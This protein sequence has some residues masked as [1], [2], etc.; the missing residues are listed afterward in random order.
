M[1]RDQTY[2]LQ[3]QDML[4]ASGAQAN[5]I[6]GLN[7]ERS[8]RRH[9]LK[10][11]FLRPVRLAGQDG[12][13][14]R[15]GRGDATVIE[16]SHII[17]VPSDAIPD[18]LA[19]SA[20]QLEQL[21]QHVKAVSFKRLLLASEN[22]I[23]I[24]LSEEPD[25]RDYILVLNAPGFDPVLKF[26][27]FRFRPECDDEFD[28]KPLTFAE[29][30][31]KSG[32]VIDYL[33]RDYQSLR[34]VL[35]DRLS[36]V[37]PDWTDR[38][39]ADPGVALVELLAYVGDYLSYRQD[40]VATEANFAFARQRSSM[41]RH[42]RLLGYSVD[43]GA[44]ARVAIQL[45]VPEDA[46][47]GTI[48]ALS[49]L[50]FLTDAVPTEY[51]NRPPEE[52]GTLLAGSAVQFFEPSD[53]DDKPD[54]QSAPDR[55]TL[56]PQHDQIPLHD[57]GDRQARLERN[58]LSA[59]LQV[60]SAPL[61]LKAGDLV[62]LSPR[63][64]PD[65][66][67]LGAD[68]RHIVRLTHIGDPVVDPVGKQGDSGPQ[69]LK[70]QRIEWCAQDALP[71]AIPIGFS[72]DGEPGGV[73]MGNLIVAD[74]GI[75]VDD[76]ETLPLTPDRRAQD[77]RDKD[78]SLAGN[79]LEDLVRPRRYRPVLKRKNIAI[80]TKPIDL[81]V[82]TPA[83]SIFGP[84]SNTGLPDVH[85]SEHDPDRAEMTVGHWRP[86][87]STIEAASTDQVF[88]AE[89]EAD[90]LT[91]LRFG[92]GRFGRSPAPNR[93]FKA[94]YRIGSGPEGNVGAG[95]IR[96]ILQRAP[97]VAPES[98][99]NPAPATGGRR[100]ESNEEIRIKAPG[101]IYRQR[102]AITADDYAART[103]A[104][105]GVQRV[106][107]KR[108]ETGSGEIIAITVDMIGGGTLSDDDKH[109]LTQWVEPYRMMGHRLLFR[110]PVFVPLD[111]RL[112][113]CPLPDADRDR[114]RQNVERRL[115]AAELS[116]GEFGFFHP[117]RLTFG[118]EI[119][120]SEIVAEAAK[121]PRV[122][123]VKVISLKRQ[124]QSRTEAFTMGRLVFSDREIPILQN[125]RQL[126][127]NGVLR[128]EM[129]GDA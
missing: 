26:L 88:V 117:D 76:G 77:V 98:C 110:S 65:N 85:L 105:E 19:L 25:P 15:E 66:L 114:I 47:N 103:M 52:L 115:S 11:H 9:I 87:V 107:V 123:S 91:Q 43:E 12:S 56:Y 109:V 57:W 95:T 23:V 94:R 100:R 122:R 29:P 32:P 118:A 89:I 86:V 14:A 78:V 62:F 40:F 54:H 49:N 70:V 3:R 129:A 58:S 10:V 120:V 41:K 8:G 61:H 121:V 106:A 72:K 17:L 30:G 90:G 48:I 7:Y 102:R 35:F 101:S 127:L 60:T 113:I 36:V 83:R 42:A 84:A 75:T 80:R 13:P 82:N 55:A 21:A 119:F 97:G 67:P 38:N 73:V 37:V 24:D 79:P 126:P 96:T 39:P 27:P 28:C 50:V 69:P 44:N 33:A 93:R 108:R 2:R 68:K 22:Q 31:R 112:E 51:A 81:A 1:L 92:D 74:H 64:D 4:R 71:H 18:P 16:T 59:W 45:K 116:G 104:F 5:G 53:L 124:R 63:P 46:V 99:W 34:R 6:T 20:S 125:D 128:I 111:L